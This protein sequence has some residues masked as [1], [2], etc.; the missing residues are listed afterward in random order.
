MIMK[1]R[2]IKTNSS[3]LKRGF[4][5]RDELELYGIDKNEIEVVQTYQKNFP[6][7]LQDVDGFTIDARVLWMQL[8]EPQGKFANWVKRK[9]IDK[10][11]VE[12]VDYEVFHKTVKNPKGGR[13]TD[14]Y[15][16][17]VDTA[18][19]ICMMENTDAGR[20]IRRYF[21]IIEKAFRNRIEWNFDR[22]DTITLHTKLKQALLVH[23]QK[24]ISHKNFPKFANNNQFI[25]ESCMLNEVI[26]GMSSKE[27]KQLNGLGKNDAIRNHFTEE[28]LEYYA[29]LQEY[30]A[31]LINLQYMYDIE[32]RRKIL[33]RKYK[34]M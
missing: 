25:A 26:I 32:E 20:F 10:G 21:I 18:K 3:N 19:N 27:Y 16:L 6:E 28:Q 17:T 9:I 30:D 15:M 7:L 23:R 34:S 4:Y 2:E 29:A 24:L 31:D 8:G 13:S 33:T 11:F 5:K 14:E 1:Q 22:D 12:N